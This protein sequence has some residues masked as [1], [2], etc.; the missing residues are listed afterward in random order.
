MNGIYRL[1]RLLLKGEWFFMAAGRGYVRR[2]LKFK[3]RLNILIH[4]LANLLRLP[5]CFGVPYTLS[6]E[7]ASICNLRCPACPAGTKIVSRRPAL[8]GLEDFKKIIDMIGDYLV[9]ILL[10]NWGEPF[11]NKDVYEM[12][13]Y[14]SRKGIIVVTSSNGHYFDSPESIDRLLSSGLANLII[15]ID[16]TTQETYEFYRAG[17][18]L[19]KVLNGMRGITN[20]KK[21]Q[22]KDFPH[23]NMRFMINSSNENQLKDFQ[24]LAYDLGADNCTFRFIY[25]GL[26]G[27]PE[28]CGYLLPS[29][30]SFVFKKVEGDYDTKCMLFWYMPVLYSNGKVGMCKMDALGEAEVRH[31]SEVTSFG[32]IWNSP[33]ARKYRREVKKNPGYGFCRDCFCREPEF[34]TVNI[35]VKYD[36]TGKQSVKVVSNRY[37]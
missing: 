21:Q 17:G 26:A 20:A 13:E 14:A 10:W 32:R 35:E 29:N 8:L 15:S 37:E 16:G 9:R 6:V 24:A 11:M 30:E 22:G 27:Q 34:D 1:Y 28:E 3:A 12:I 18:N 4:R 7:P 25:T 31:I 2:G 5:Y 19:E 36:S 23:I 33:T